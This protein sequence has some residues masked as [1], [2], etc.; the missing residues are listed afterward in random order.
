MRAKLNIAFDL[1][2]VLFDWNPEKLLASLYS[3]QGI[4]TQIMQSV[5]QHQDWTDLDRGVLDEEPAIERFATRTQLPPSQIRTLIQATRK[6]LTPKDASWD[7]VKELHAEQV[8]LY[9]ISNMPANTY[10]YLQAHYDYWHYFKGVVISAEIGQVKPEPAIFE[11]LLKHYALQADETLFID[12]YQ[13]NVTAARAVG[14]SAIHF[15]DIDN[16]QQ[17][18]HDLLN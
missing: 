5:Y 11:Y 8:P 14:L 10:R 16:C 3:D 2:G 9:V 6:S 7:L 18:I 17:Q 4:R 1:G 15:T 12:D 13:D